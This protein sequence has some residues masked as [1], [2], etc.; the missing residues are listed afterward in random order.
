MISFESNIGWDARLV[1]VRVQMTEEL[2]R[3]YE[4][5]LDILAGSGSLDLARALNRRGVVKVGLQGA[6]RKL[7]GVVREASAMGGLPGGLFWY[8]LVLVPR[9][10]LLDLTSRSRVFCTERPG[11]VAD[12]IADVLTSAQDVQLTAED[13]RTNLHGTAYPLRDMVVQYQESD[14]AFISRLAEGAGIFYMFQNGEDG[15]QIIFGDSNLAFPLLRNGADGEAVVFR[16]GVGIA[17][18]GP[19]VRS[20]SLERRLRPSGA[21]L[22]ERFY[23][24]PQTVLGVQSVAVPDGVGTLTWQEQDGYADAA[25][26]QALA[27]IRAQEA[28]CGRALLRGESDCLDMAA[29]RLF[30]LT[31]HPSAHFN[32]RY[33]VTHVTHEVWE[34]AMGIEYLP[35]PGPR[36]RGYAN[37]FTAIPRDVP[38]RPARRTPMPRIAGMIRATVDGVDDERPDID[39]LGCYRIIFSFDTATRPPGKSSCPVRLLTPY[40]GP[41][42]G[43]HF[44]LRAKT[45]VMVAF[46]NGDPDRPVILGPLYD[47]DQKSVVTHANRTA[48]IISTVA[49]ITLK[50]NDGLP[51]RR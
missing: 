33:I 22:D 13:Y 27:D 35:G 48:N 50:M 29:G 41:A 37:R 7:H 20:V 36:G 43:F 45:Q 1:P 10:A 32:G 46:Q 11:R 8:R 12:V 26:G 31:G 2:S 34:S 42:E 49:G 5:T 4:V 38:F 23:A 24:S 15:E 39:A 19:A 51:T 18:P 28:A 25:W 44:P 3:C 47:A 17:D 9:L 16:P 40:G 21:Q 14:L 30:T 6:E